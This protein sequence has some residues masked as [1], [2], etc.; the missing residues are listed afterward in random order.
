MEKKKDMS[1]SHMPNNLR[2]TK[3]TYYPTYH[4]ICIMWQNRNSFITN[5]F[6]LLSLKK[7][8]ESEISFSSR[9]SSIDGGEIV[10]SLM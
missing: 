10:R 8:E 9:L 1:G 7:S 5:R 6:F 3:R 2:T 4:S